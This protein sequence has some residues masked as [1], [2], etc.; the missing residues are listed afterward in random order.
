MQDGIGLGEPMV[1]RVCR[2]CANFED[3]RDIDN[4]ALCARNVGPNVCCEDFEPKHETIDPDRLYNRFC[5]DCTNFEDSNGMILCYQN[6]TPI[7]SCDEFKSRFDRLKATNQNN[8]KKTVLI[9]YIATHYN[10]KPVP[11]SL[12]KIGQTIK[13]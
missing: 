7:V 11:K 1:K 4:A 10:P 6:H 8:N 5:V 9:T 13:W 2:D 12:I 3:R